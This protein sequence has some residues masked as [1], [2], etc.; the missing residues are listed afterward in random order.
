VSNKPRRRGGLQGRPSETQR[1]AEGM[2]PAAALA[3]KDQNALL[4]SISAVEPD[5]EQPRR[6]FD[7][8]ALAQ[9]AES[10]KE[11]GILQPLLVMERGQTYQLVS[12]ERRLRAAQQAGL[13]SVP[14]RVVT[15][16]S[17]VREIQLVE[18][19]QR[20]DLPLMD[21][22]RALKE[23]QEALGTS[24]REL[25]QAIGKDKNY[26]HRRLQVL[27]FPA[28]VQVMLQQAPHLFTK[29][30]NL[31]KIQDPQRRAKQIKRL[32]QGDDTE[33]SPAPAQRGRPAKP[34][35][36]QPKKDGGFELVVKYRPRQD[37]RDAII[38]ELENILEHLKKN[39]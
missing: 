30:A 28:D 39:S 6:H 17:K 9:L 21:E 1:R 38:E 5:P 3:G 8:E 4:V 29:A 18:N 35:R 14:V 10:I 32:L 15:D 31:A 16:P 11:Q 19:L 27:D 7:D 13:T 37:N 26:V 24:G 25:A 2:H 23:L 12:G 33:P 22:A 34:V 36:Y 20:E